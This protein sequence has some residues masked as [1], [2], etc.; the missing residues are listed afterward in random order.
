MCYHYKIT[1]KISKLE[2][3]FKAEMTSEDKELYR[4]S[5]HLNGYNHP[6]LPVI[7]N[8]EPH[9]IQRLSWGLIPFWAKDSKI[10]NSTLNAK[11][12]TADQL[13][14]FKHSV[15]NRCLV[16]ADG[17]FEWKHLDENGKQKQCYLISLP[18]NI[19]FAFA[20]LFSKWQHPDTGQ[21]FTSYTILTTPANQLMS[22]IH[23]SG[24]R[25]PVILQAQEESDFINGKE[26]TAFADRD[27]VPLIATPVD[28]PLK[29]TIE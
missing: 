3:R 6:L 29:R 12:E 10:S 23:N 16:L 9:R 4:E 21:H 7:T 8:Q 1:K 5:T 25:M 28:S 15:Q 20:G 19:P 18:D 13:P 24:L 27:Q 17:F 26:L 22:K 2:E 14:S 11:I